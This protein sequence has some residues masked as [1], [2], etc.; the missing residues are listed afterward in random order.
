MKCPP[1][2]FDNALDPV[3]LE[4]AKNDKAEFLKMFQEAKNAKM[5][6]L[7]RMN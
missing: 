4:K 1:R 7:D 2:R 5:Q 6:H 3:A